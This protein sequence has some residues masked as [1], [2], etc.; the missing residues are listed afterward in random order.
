MQYVPG[1]HGF[2]CVRQPA[3]RLVQETVP[4]T[5]R[6]Q[7]PQPAIAVGQ[8]HAELIL[9]GCR[10]V[11]HQ[12]AMYQQQCKRG[13][14][15]RQC[16]AAKTCQLVPDSLVAAEQKTVEKKREIQ[17]VRIPIANQ[18]VVDVRKTRIHEIAVEYQRHDRQKDQ[19]GAAQALKSGTDGGSWIVEEFCDR[20]Q[21]QGVRQQVGQIPEMSPGPGNNFDAVPGLGWELLE[22]QVCGH[23]R[24]ETGLDDTF[25]QGFVIGLRRR[26]HGHAEYQRNEQTPNPPDGE[27]CR[28]VLAPDKVHGQAGNHEDQRHTP[29]VRPEHRQLQPV[30]PIGGLDVPIPFG[31]IEHTDVVKN[32]QPECENA[33]CVD[34][35]SPFHRASL[36]AP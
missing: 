11:R 7:Q 10:I 22:R 9:P 26:D 6:G 2:R 8:E 16:P 14:G 24:A 33:E 19:P 27:S 1:I 28:R 30:A 12:L 36:V 23:K 21:R 4:P 5:Q 20:N 31:D 18:V 13:N 29:L 32:Q 34:I 35:V 3:K 17:R 15:Q 25:R